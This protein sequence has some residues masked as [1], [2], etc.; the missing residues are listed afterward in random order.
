MD[1]SLTLPTVEEVAALLYHEARLLDDVRYE[2]W[3]ELFTKDGLYWLPVSDDE[4]AGKADP[5]RNVQIIFDDPERRAERVWRTLNTPVLDQNPRSRTIH[6]VSNIEVAPEP[7]DGEA[8][9]WC[10]QQVSELRPGGLRQIGLN[11]QRMFA[12]RCEYRLRRLDG[13]WLISMKKVL[14]L[15]RDLPIFNLTFV[16]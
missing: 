15:D 6:A 1:D 5:A 16:F 12:A 14:L 13:Q 10:V 7:V 3:L 11:H 8:L 4:D 9:V 2:D